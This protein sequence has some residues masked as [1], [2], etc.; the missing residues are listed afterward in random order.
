MQCGIMRVE[1]RGRA[2]V[3]GLQIEANRTAEDHEQGR[4][5]A[6]SDIDWSKTSENV[7]LIKTEKWNQAITARL[8]DEGLK[9][10]KDSVVMLDGLYTA[11]PEFFTGKSKDEI[12]EYFGDCLDFHV[13]AYC[14]GDRSRLL[15]ARVHFDETTPHL[16]IQ[17]IPIYKDEKGKMHL[18]A[19]LIMGG[20]GDYQRRQNDFFEQVTQKR[21]LDRGELHDE[22]ERKKHKKV[23]D[24]QIEQQKEKLAELDAALARV[25]N[26]RVEKAA[27]RAVRKEKGIIDKKTVYEISENDWAVVKHASRLTGRAINAQ[28]DADERAA[29]A[30]EAKKEAD[31]RT[32]KERRGRQNVERQRDELRERFGFILNAPDFVEGEA[33]KGV[34]NI[35]QNELLY[36]RDVQRDCVRA[37]ITARRGGNPKT[38]LSETVRKMS[39]NL[40]DIGI[41]GTRAQVN[42]IKKC[43]SEASKQM[44]REYDIDKKGNVKGRKKSVPSRQDGGAGGWSAPQDK[45]DYLHNEGSVVGAGGCPRLDEGHEHEGPW[46]LLPWYVQ[47]EIEDREF[48]K[49][50]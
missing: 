48:W 2:A 18:S 8:K 16:T 20:R 4:D 35:R 19:K 3:Y 40:E 28:K 15:N 37:F 22:G 29:A 25:E 30:E 36:Q 44:H 27:G 1:K 9:T 42:Y 14:Q 47:Q 7:D 13:R 32:A 45:T 50:I 33:R 31:E 26:E 10:R 43:L 11:S 24:W 6:A 12:M 17:S 5:F 46:S 23:R 38:A 41:H 34:E 39:S 49:T 21:G